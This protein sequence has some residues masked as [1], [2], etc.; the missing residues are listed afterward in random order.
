MEEIKASQMSG[1]A[2]HHHTGLFRLKRSVSSKTQCLTIPS[3]LTL[4]IAVLLKRADCLQLSLI[5][6]ECTFIKY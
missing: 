1:P 6:H 4:V 3:F 2:R 5:K